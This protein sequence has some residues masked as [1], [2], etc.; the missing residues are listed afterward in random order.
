MPADKI[1]VRSHIT[2]VIARA[3]TGSLATAPTPAQG[4]AA[5]ANFETVTG[6]PLY[7]STQ[8]QAM[9]NEARARI[10]AGEDPVLILWHDAQ[11]AAIPLELTGTDFKTAGDDRDKSIM[12][13]S[14]AEVGFLCALILGRDV[15][16][17]YAPSTLD[18]S[19]LRVSLDLSGAT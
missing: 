12:P 10:T 6:P 15:D 4:L 1:I 7:G 16:L 3:Q 5:D 17:K 14:L 18:L 11:D 19:K 13:V 2:K 8:L 9:L